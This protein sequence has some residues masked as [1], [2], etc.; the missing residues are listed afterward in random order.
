[1]KSK[2]IYSGMPKKLI[3]S[4]EGDLILIRA[5]A[6]VFA[7]G[8]TL[9]AHIIMDRGLGGEVPVYWV[10]ENVSDFKAAVGMKVY[11]QDNESI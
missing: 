1:M 8:K 10:K 4:I 5:I 3:A 9:R 11:V 7:I 2:F 6:A